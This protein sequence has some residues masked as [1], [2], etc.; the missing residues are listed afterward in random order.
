LEEL[1]EARRESALK[2]LRMTN[3]DVILDGCSQL[4]PPRAR[5]LD[6]GCAHGWFLEAARRRGYEAVGIEPDNQMAAI[7]HLAGHDVRVGLFPN[8]LSGA[9]TYDAIVFNDVFEHLPDVDAAVR[10]IR[11]HLNEG[12]V[13]V[14]NLPVSDGLIFRLARI[15]ARLGLTGVLSRMWQ[16]GF[17]SP[18]LSYFSKE[19]LPRFMEKRGLRLLAS[20]RLESVRTEGLF[21]RIRYDKSIGV[22]KAIALYVAAVSIGLLTNL[23]PSDIHFFVFKKSSVH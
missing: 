1:D 6:V 5:M 4:I 13:V 23:F 19:T 7:A 3:Y 16:Q 17:P 10:S 8:A 15:A 22:P 9:E 20:G 2:S 14:I 18:H 21:Q 12:G 11:A